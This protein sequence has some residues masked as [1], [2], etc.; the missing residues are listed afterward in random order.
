MESKSNS[1]PVRKSAISTVSAIVLT[2][3]IVGSVV[4]GAASYF[5]TSR[6]DAIV[7]EI[8][9]QND[10]TSSQIANALSENGRLKVDVM[11]L[12]DENGKLKSQVSAVSSDLR[13]VADVA[14]IP[15]NNP[16]E[17]K[18]LM[19]ERKVIEA[20]KQEGK[21]VVYS[22]VDVRTFSALRSAF[23]TI[24]PSITVE[25]VSAGTGA[26]T[27]RFVGEFDKGIKSADV[28]QNN[29]AAFGAVLKRD[30]LLAKYAPKD[31][32]WLTAD[33]KD[34][35][36]KWAAYGVTLG[37]LGYNTKLLSKDAAPKSV[38]DIIDPKWDGKRG[39]SD[40][41]ANPAVIDFFRAYEKEFGEGWMKQF[42]SQ[43]VRYYAS[44]SAVTDKLASG[45]VSI[46]LVAIAGIESLKQTGQPVDW[47]RTS[48]NI[49]FVNYGWIGIASNAPHPN[50]A[51]LFEDFVM[52]K[53]GQQI[54]ADFGNVPLMP[55]VRLPNPDLSV[56][57]KKLI[58]VETLSD[59]ERQALLAKYPALAP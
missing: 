45:E 4:G 7:A 25:L 59:A 58:T 38:K 32:G 41:K 27:D 20:A 31:S 9:S 43:K 19:E 52:S 28:F 17:M 23:E 11:A 3:I 44:N 35:D 8:K 54:L 37:V 40:F 36:G 50:A 29:Q 15:I 18:K 24:Y 5:S 49:Y 57:G 22:A 12:Q 48:D 51:R 10:K 42:A 30:T 33:Q 39:N 6:A 2:A 14:G 34:K 16:E 1:K 46:A 21:V 56:Q 26:L 55:G 47:V 53:Q 13:A